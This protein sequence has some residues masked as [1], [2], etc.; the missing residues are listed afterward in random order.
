LNAQQTHLFLSFESFR[1]LD[2]SCCHQA[3]GTGLTGIFPPLKNS[4]AV[5]NDDPTDQITAIIH[6]LSG[7]TIDGV[8]YSTPMPSF[9]NLLSDE[10]IVAVAN[11]LRTQWGNNGRLINKT[12]VTP[13]R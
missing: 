8:S 9:G 4:A 6:G 3:A 10:D 12:K 7:K 2:C 1:I 11:H 13:L 5:L